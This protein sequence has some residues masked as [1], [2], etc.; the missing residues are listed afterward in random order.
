[1]VVSVTFVPV[2]SPRSCGHTQQRL[3]QAPNVKAILA[4]V[5]KYHLAPSSTTPACSTLLSWSTEV[6]SRVE[7]SI[8]DGEGAVRHIFGLFLSPRR[9]AALHDNYPFCG[10]L[11]H[12]QHMWPGYSVQR[13]FLSLADHDVVSGFERG[14]RSI[15]ATAPYQTIP[16]HVAL[17]GDHQIPHC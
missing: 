9:I 3:I 11:N 16:L 10:D 15:P 1:M 13:S 7:S 4:F 8:Q 2:T 6:A 17:L 5:T 14:L 12:S